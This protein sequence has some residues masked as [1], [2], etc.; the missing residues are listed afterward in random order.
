MLEGEKRMKTMQD[1][2]KETEHH[3]DSKMQALETQRSANKIEIERLEH[4][5]STVAVTHERIQM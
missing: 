2:I 5:R 4:L 3:I 1:Q